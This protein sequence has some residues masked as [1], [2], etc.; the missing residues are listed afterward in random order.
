[1]RP[2][3]HAKIVSRK[4]SID[5][6]G[7]EVHNI[8]LLK[9]VPNV[10]VLESTD[11]LALMRVTP[12]QIDHLLVIFDVVRPQL[13]FKWPL[14]L[15]N[16]LDIRNL[17]TNATMATEYSLLFIRDDGCQWQVVEGIVDLSKAAIRIVDIL[18]KSLCAL[19]SE[20]KILIY[21]SVL[22]IAS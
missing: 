16:A 20:P 5:V 15:L 17:R 9:R 7:P 10:I 14:Y 2:D 19:I 11:F 21:V 8:V 12:E 18:S 1:M 6:V 3:Q 22:V 13:D 4:E